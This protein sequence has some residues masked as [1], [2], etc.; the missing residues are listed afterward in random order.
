[1]TS[2]YGCSVGSDH[3]GM[4]SAFT[5]M[6][7]NDPELPD[8]LYIEDAERESISRDE[9]GDIKRYLDLF[10]EL[11][12]MADKSGGFAEQIERIRGERFA[13]SEK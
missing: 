10:I 12:R 7:F 13:M 5:V 3:R 8:L 1:M 6:Q 4:G 11:Q 2:T 9:A